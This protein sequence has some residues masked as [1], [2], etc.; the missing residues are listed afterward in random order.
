M[1]CSGR[2]R[3]IVEGNAETDAEYRTLQHDEQAGGGDARGG[4]GFA[5]R[6]VDDLAE[7]AEAVDLLRLQPGEHLGATGFHGDAGHR[8]RLRQE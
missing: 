2:C 7:A 1:Y 4:K 6:G 3:V 5:R 8:A